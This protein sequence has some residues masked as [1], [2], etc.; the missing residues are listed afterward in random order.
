[1]I[2]IYPFPFINQLFVTEVAAAV[3]TAP[4]RLLLANTASD[5]RIS[6]SV[7]NL[8][9]LPDHVRMAHC[10]VKEVNAKADRE[11]QATVQRVLDG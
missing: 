8:A 6:L 1:M 11:N 4:D 3:F 7:P 9:L 5:W 10:A 2:A